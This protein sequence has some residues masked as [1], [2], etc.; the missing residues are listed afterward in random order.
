MTEGHLA[1][2][3]DFDDTVVAIFADPS[4]VEKAVSDLSAADYEY[5]VLEGEAGRRHL[6]PT[7]ESGPVAT[8]KRL[9]ISFGDQ[10]RIA[11]RLSQDLQ[12]G[13]VVISVNAGPDEAG[14]ASEILKKYGGEFIWQ[15]GAWTF[16]QIEE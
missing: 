16:T 7:D 12:K 11:E 8:V 6:D 10:S 15:L 9:L 3:H 13:S 14:K 2:F 1:D 4:L 5:E